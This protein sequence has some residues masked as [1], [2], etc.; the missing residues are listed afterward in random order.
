MDLSCLGFGNYSSF[1]NI[2]FFIGSI[3]GII[4]LLKLGVRKVD[5]ELRGDSISALTWA[6][7]E[8][9]R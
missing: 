6:H 5:I 8:R 2:C 3:L 9:Y 7:V 1:W 4:D